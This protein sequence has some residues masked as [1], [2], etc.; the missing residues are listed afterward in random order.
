M[1]QKLEVVY[2]PIDSLHPYE[3]NARKHK[4]ADISVIKESIEKF[5]FDDPIAIWS[6]KN[7]VVAGHGRLLAAKALNYTEVPCIRLD[8]LTDEE[9]KAYALTHNRSAELSEWDMDTLDEELRALESEFELDKLGFSAFL[10]E[11]EPIEVKD[12]DFDEDLF[13][14][15][16]PET[17]EGDIYILG[18]HRLICGDSTSPTVVNN[19]VDG[20]EVDLVLTDPPYN[21]DYVGKTAEALKIKNDK[22]TKSEFYNFLLKAFINMYEVAKPGCPCFVFHADKEETNFREATEEAGFKWHQNA[23]WLKDTFVMGHSWMHYRYEPILIEWKEG[24][25]HFDKGDRTIDNVLQFDRPKR[26]LEHPTMK[27]LDLIGWLIDFGCEK[28]DIVLDLFGGSGSTLIACEESLRTC[29]TAELDPKYCDVI[30]KRYIRYK[31]T[32][33]NCYRIRNG[34]KEELDDTE[35]ASVLLL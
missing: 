7:I 1:N 19:L 4:E 34:V 22:K 20:K 5:G 18:R 12:D 2:L 25:A 32:L 15:E 24:A 31:G 21:V 10:E 28:D 33:A 35:L 14:P 6:D 16:E 23:I 27:P 17:K 9:R 13:V 29:F 30:V 11:D 26:S 3:K 8:H